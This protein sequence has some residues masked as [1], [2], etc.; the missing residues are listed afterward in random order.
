MSDLP[1]RIFL[2]HDPE[3][4]GEPFS[5]AHEVTWCTD[6][7]NDNDCEYIR[8]DV[9]G[10]SAEFAPSLKRV[11][12]EDHD[13]RI[14]RLGEIALYAIASWEKWHDESLGENPDESTD[15]RAEVKKLLSDG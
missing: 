3:E 2:Q 12:Q 7:I 4:T 10:R 11:I 6:R 13:R 9:A 15:L 1:T 8:A 14:K 5:E